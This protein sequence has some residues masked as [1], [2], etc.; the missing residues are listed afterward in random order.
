M[1]SWCSVKRAAAA[2]VVDDDDNDDT[3]YN[4][5][6][7]TFY[8]LGLDNW[9]SSYKG[10]FYMTKNTADTALNRFL[11]SH[12]ADFCFFWTIIW[13]Q[14]FSCSIWRINSKTSISSRPTSGT[15]SGSAKSRSSSST[16][17]TLSSRWSSS[18]PTFTPSRLRRCIITAVLNQLHYMATMKVVLK[19]S[20]LTTV[21]TAA[22]SSPPTL[23]PTL[24][25]QLHFILVS[26]LFFFWRAPNWYSPETAR[27]KTE[28]EAG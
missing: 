21:A 28:T 9:S 3:D 2:A 15:L 4:E 24:A 5:M 22:L 25:L 11:S 7:T 10:K 8:S 12:F 23:Y 18:L 13:P 26:F 14:E 20:T 16:S 6:S 19:Q 27:G 1:P 17:S